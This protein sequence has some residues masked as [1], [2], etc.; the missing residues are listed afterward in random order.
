MNKAYIDPNKCLRCLKCNAEKS[1]PVKAI[2]RID[3]EESAVVETGLCHGC[4]DCVS[5]CVVDAIELR[6]V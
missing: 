6:N 5:F 2:F 4:G 1:C 3:Y